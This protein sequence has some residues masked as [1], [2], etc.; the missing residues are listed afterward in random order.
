M[1]T[2]VNKS[3]NVDM[4]I[5]IKKTNKST[6]YMFYFDV[7]GATAEFTTLH[8]FLHIFFFKISTR[9]RNKS[10]GISTS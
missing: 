1:G 8:I 5:G 3:E 10:I 7:A 6:Y 4:G 9:T 2:Q